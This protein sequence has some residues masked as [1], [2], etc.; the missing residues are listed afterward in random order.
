MYITPDEMRTIEERAERLGV[1][2]L[3][4]MENAGKSVADFIESRFGARGKRI[5]IIAGTG[6][7]GGDGFVAARHLAAYGATVQVFL[8]GE[9]EDIRSPRASANLEVLERM[10]SVGLTRLSD[11]SFEEKLGIAL[12]EADVL[13]DAIFGTGI[14]GELREPHASIIDRINMSRAFKLAVDVPSGLDPSTGEICGRAV[15]ADATITFHRAKI[16]L[17][18]R[19]DLVGELVVA[20][21]GVPPEAEVT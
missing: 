19:K 9:R 21:I 20:N 4:M 1:S 10:R 14:K 16:G 13:V 5:A 12:L 3:L 7:N 2:R 11:E 18:V 15:N 8:I 6:D 17:R